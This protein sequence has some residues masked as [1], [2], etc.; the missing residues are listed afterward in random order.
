V[1]AYKA[2]SGSAGSHEGEDQLSESWVSWKGR[3]S[4]ALLFGFVISYILVRLIE[5]HFL[6]ISENG[7]LLLA[8][9]LI[10]WAC[11]CVVLNRIWQ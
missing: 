7:T 3:Q 8:L 2:Y 4:R 10:V 9:F 1:K 6:P 5:K 11:L